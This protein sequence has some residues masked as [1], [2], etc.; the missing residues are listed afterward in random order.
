MKNFELIRENAG[1]LF[2][3][4]QDKLLKAIDRKEVIL[5]NNI[6]LS[7]AAEI[8]KMKSVI[9]LQY[10]KGLGRM[11]E[12][13]RSHLGDS[14]ELEKAYFSCMKDENFKV[15]FEKTGIKQVI[16]TGIEAH[17]CVF[18]TARDMIKEGYEV[19]IVEDAIGSRSDTNYKNA[20]KN[21]REVGCVITTT[22]TV[23]F[24]ILKTARTDEFKAVQ[25][26]IK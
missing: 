23:L 12:E 5:K 21:L 20:L 25:N 18:Q 8:M 1:F 9:T 19:F 26:L 15:E 3:D 24:D 17:I 2:V 11:N 6:I 4:V 10:P 22:E 14:K 13:I 16:M 7:K